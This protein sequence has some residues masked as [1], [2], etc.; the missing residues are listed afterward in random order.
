MLI[1][2]VIKQRFLFKI[3]AKRSK[4]KEKDEALK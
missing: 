4:R 1:H 3:R 2:H